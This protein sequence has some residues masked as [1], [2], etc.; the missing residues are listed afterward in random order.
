MRLPVTVWI[1][2]FKLLSP[3]ILALIFNEYL[4]YYVK[5]FYQCSWPEFKDSLRLSTLEETNHRHK[6]SEAPKDASS[7]S[8]LSSSFGSTLSSS[9]DSPIQL[10]IFTDTHLLGNLRG[11]PLDKLRREWQ[12]YRSF[13]TAM[14]LFQPSMVV[15]LGDV[16]DEGLIASKE[17]F[18]QYFNRFQALFHVEPS[19]KKL[20]V[21]GNHDIGFHD[22][23]QAYEPF[24][25]KRFEDAFNT[26]LVKNVS[27]HGIDFILINSMALEGDACNFCHEAEIKIKHL[28]REVRKRCGTNGTITTC[29]R[30]I[31]LM[32]FPLYRESEEECHEEDSATDSEE[33][34]KKYRETIDCVS[35][36]STLFLLKE[37]QP[38]IVFNG[39]THHGCVKKHAT[40]YGFVEEWTVSSFSWRNRPNPSFLLV[41]IQIDSKSP[42]KY[43][44]S[45]SKCILPLETTV[46]F[47]YVAATFATF[48]LVYNLFQE[49]FKRT[50]DMKHD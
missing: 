14:E 11:H 18:G 24:L 10:F 23:I 42:A 49:K 40:S 45:I 36:Q 33:I 16:F 38:R 8:T 32:H 2:S 44:V 43:S 20:I 30:P 7:D 21:V 13:Q 5:L 17:E 29:N 47:I 34:T 27:L 12:M 37:L 50:N 1:L 6:D 15:H 25:R 22:R 26:T 35:K 46:L 28:G 41:T 19:V 48:V 39:H 9:S 3:I 4:I 31:V